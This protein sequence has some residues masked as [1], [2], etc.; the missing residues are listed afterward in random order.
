MQREIIL[1]GALFLIILF[2]VKA[3]DLFRSAPLE[4]DAS[5][6]VLE[7][8]KNKYPN[9]DVGIITIQKKLNRENTPYFEVKAKLV[10]NPQTPCPE[11]SHI[12][13]N[14]P[15]QNFVAQPIE[16]ITANCKVCT[17]GICTINFPEE[18][19][20][21]SHSNFE[22]DSFIKSNSD[23]THS[24]SEGDYWTVTWYSNKAKSGYIVDVLK[25]GTIKRIQKSTV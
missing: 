12:Y 25:N 9:S 14:Y 23:S 21:A 13:Y 3:S 17:E 4:S 8:L 7:D 24:V 18:A 10:Q 5:K 15:E 6:F 20:I 16:V 19:I 11:L 1:I 2:L 22:V